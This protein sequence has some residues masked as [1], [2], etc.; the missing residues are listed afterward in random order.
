MLQTGNLASQVYYIIS[1]TKNYEG[2]VI[3]R[4]SFKPVLVDHLGHNGSDN[5][6]LV[7]TNHD[8]NKIDPERD[9]RRV[10]VEKRL[11]RLGNNLT[12]QD[13]FDKIMSVS[14]SFNNKTIFST[15]Q[16]AEDGF[17]NT[18]VY[19]RDFDEK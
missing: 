6:F 9:Y 2:A 3:A 14:P 18:T 5:W 13:A 15:I 19:F 11:R 10:P 12:Y 16:A 7:Q 8:R 1:G 17:F 4:D